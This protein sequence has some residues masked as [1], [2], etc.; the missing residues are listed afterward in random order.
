M[1]YVYLILSAKL[2]MKT[3]HIMVYHAVVYEF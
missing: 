3:F 1:I 2:V